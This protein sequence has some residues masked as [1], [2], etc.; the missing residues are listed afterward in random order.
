M[1]TDG[2]NNGGP[3][4]LQ[5]SAHER[6]ERGKAPRYRRLFLLAVSSSCLVSLSPLFIMAIINYY[7]YQKAFVEEV[8]H[9]IRLSISNLRRSLAFYF[10][11]RQ[12]ALRYVVHDRPFE[13]LAEPANL[14]RVFQNMQENFDGIVDLGL[15]DE[16]G[17][18]DLLTAMGAALTGAGS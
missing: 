11:E 1:G 6:R 17:I 15:V 14:A 8:T 3:A 2:V 18:Q 5:A 13:Y 4:G 9:P 12:A 7:Q 10:E 16:R